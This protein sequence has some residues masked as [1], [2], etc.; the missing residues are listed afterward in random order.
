MQSQT[1]VVMLTVPMKVSP[2][3]HVR[4]LIYIPSVFIYTHI[5]TDNSQIQQDAEWSYTLAPID[6]QPFECHVGPNTLIADD[7]LQI[8][9]LFF[10]DEML[11]GIVD[12]SNKYAETTMPAEKWANFALYTSADLKPYL[13]FQILMSINR[14]PSLGDYWSMNPNLQYRPVA[15]RISQDRFRELQHFLHFVDNSKVVPRGESGHDRLGKVRPLLTYITEKCKQLYSP[16]KEVTVDKAMIK[17]QGRSSMKQYLPMKPTK[18]GIK[19]WVLADAHTGYFSNFSVYTGKEGSKSE[20]GLCSKV[21]K[22]LTTG[23]KGLYYHVY[24][25]NYF[26]SLSLIV[27]LLKDGIYACGVARKDRKYF[28]KQLTVASLKQR[29]VV[30]SIKHTSHIIFY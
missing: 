16:K 18:R 24:F 7:P 14:L 23:L 1:L 26:T 22:K 30:H 21:V 12:A 27:D 10:T 2:M 29:L 3:W 28:P 20:V 6:I 9:Q 17:F 5:F 13:G 8:F 4:T 25:D 11:E 15:D 19:V